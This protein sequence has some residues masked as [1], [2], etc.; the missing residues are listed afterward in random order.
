MALTVSF[1]ATESIAYNNLITLND[2][3]SGTD[4]T[5]TNR[6]VYITTADGTMLADGTDW[7]YANASQVFDVLTQSTSPTIRVDWLAG[8]TVVYTYID[9]FCFDLYDYV[10][11]LGLLSNQ[12]GNPGIIQDT[13]Y[14]SNFFSFIVNLWN[15]EEAISKGDDVYSSQG[16]LDRN[17]NL[18]NNDAFYF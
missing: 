1:T 18:I 10:F 9:T 12:T 7:P 4:G 8:S 15:A 3:S 5:I 14:Y 17:Q 11:A 6:K 16:A 13:S 2:T